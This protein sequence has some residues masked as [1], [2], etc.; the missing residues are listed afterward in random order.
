MPINKKIIIKKSTE[1]LKFTL[2][3]SA[4]LILSGCQT[5]Q[6]GGNFLK[7]TFASDDPCSNNARNIGVTTGA[8]L[9]ALAGHAIG[10][11]R[12]AVVIGAGAGALLG[13]FIGR[14][15]DQ[16]RCELFKIAQQ[17][18]M[19]MQ[20]EDIQQAQDNGKSS[21]QGLSVSIRE[22]TAQFP[23]GSSKLTPAGRDAFTAI[24]KT[25][26]QPVPDAQAAESAARMQK[27]RIL[28]VGHTD[29]TGSS[30]QNAQLAEA[31]ARAV[32]EVFA[33]QGFNRNQI[34][35]Q[36][37]GET[38]PV[39]SNSDEAGRARNRR[40]EIIDLSDEVAFANY[41]SGG[42]RTNTAFYREASPQPTQDTRS[43]QKTAKATATSKARTPKKTSTP[44][45][46]TSVVTAA[47][48]HPSTATASTTTSTSAQVK[49]R[50]QLGSVDFGGSPVNGRPAVLA[51][52]AAPASSSFSWLPTAQA[53]DTTTLLSCLQDRPRIAHGVKSLDTG[54]LRTTDYLPGVYD[55][56]WVAS[57][58]GHLVALNHVAVLRDGA[59]PARKPELQIYSNYQGDAK[60]KPT[61]R[62]APEVN[63]YM[64]QN[65]LLYRVF[66]AGPVQCMD[67]LIPHQRA[68]EAIAGNLIYPGQGDYYQTEITPRLAK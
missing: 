27:M 29:D 59:V 26:R 58:N 64:G 46:T 1:R 37:A 53:T 24:A 20:F 42:R 21:T 55:S 28:L 14:D 65:G 32:A 25:Y 5:T 19:D 61:F 4:V 49:P 40:V 39:A 44:V 12:A 41:L 22:T 48:K 6:G 57:V 35:Y 2:C 56:S 3:A 62:G 30:A 66:S 63:A 16:Q 52:G 7:E 10:D 15:I 8:I 33:A 23:V 38:L 9:G 34:F 31:R 54:K 50:I 60:A 17:H 43:T 18:S 67:I 11:K 45:D 13:G 47:G 51:L 36:G 68:K